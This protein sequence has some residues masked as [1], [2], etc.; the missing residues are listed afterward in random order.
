MTPPPLPKISCEATPR[1]PACVDAHAD[2][3]RWSSATAFVSSSVVAFLF[4]PLV[5]DASD[6]FGRVPFLAAGLGLALLP[7]GVVAGHL[8]LPDPGSLLL[9]YYP[10]SVI[11]GAVPSLVAC[12]SYTADVLPPRHRTGGFGLIIAA[13]SVGFI[14]GPLIG[15]RIAPAAA[16]FTALGATAA[17]AA[18]AA[19]LVPESLP[20]GVAARARE[21]AAAAAS[22]AGPRRRRGAAATLSAALLPALP[23]LRRSWGLVTGRRLFRR[24]AVT[25]AI[26]GAVQGGVQELV[27]Q[28]LQLRLGF[29]TADQGALFVVLGASNLAVQAALLPLLAPRLGERGLLLLGLGVSAL[30]Q[31][32]LAVVAAKWQAL[33]AVALGGLGG[34][35]FPAISALKANACGADEQGLVQGALAG[36]R[37]LS[38]GLGP[39]AFSAL[40]AACTTTR[41]ALAGRPGAVFWVAS[42]LTA[43]AAGVAATV[44]AEGPAAAAATA[45]EEEEEYVV[46]VDPAAAAASAAAAAE[47]AALR[48]VVVADDTAGSGSGGARADAAR[49]PAAAKA[50]AARSSDAGAD[51]APVPDKAPAAAAAPQRQ[52]QQPMAGPSRKQRN[53][54]QQQR[55]RAAA[56]AAPAGADNDAA[57][58]LLD[59]D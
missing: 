12:L 54:R 49:A 24:L 44:R 36:I 19:L 16:A 3:V 31:A 34:V 29:T 50:A 32:L 21:A 30:E 23:S 39:L 4:A 5:G 11:A 51:A 48:E 33:A 17:C 22:A 47:A 13:F 53:K 18:A 52:E 28:Y 10:A 57:R 55:S 9:W 35:S 38:S 37:A 15:A 27:V 56:A 42:A 58:P 1:L 43:A 7:A 41:G 40:F 59:N 45:G 46:V 14:V 25:L 2:V 8:A 26:V 6:A 20:P